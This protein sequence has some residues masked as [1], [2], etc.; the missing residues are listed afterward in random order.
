M[1][2]GWCSYACSLPELYHWSFHLKTCLLYTN[3]RW[4]LVWNK[5]KQKKKYTDT[6]RHDI[7]NFCSIGVCIL[8]CCSIITS[9]S[10]WLVSRSFLSI[11][12][13]VCISNGEGIASSHKLDSSNK[14]L[15]LSIRA[16][17]IKLI[18]WTCSNLLITLYSKVLGFSYRCH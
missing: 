16:S 3:P 8:T 17:Q 2:L 18:I 15:A 9:T 13:P 10:S 7:Y 12:T 11:A 4:N 5:T 6:T 1:D 14:C